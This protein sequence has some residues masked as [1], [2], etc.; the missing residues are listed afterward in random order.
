MCYLCSRTLFIGGEESEIEY[1]DGKVSIKCEAYPNG[2]PEEVFYSGHIYPKP[3]DN[4][5]HYEPLNPNWDIFSYFER[6]QEEEDSFYQYLI[7]RKGAK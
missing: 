1:K 2:V 7:K 5:L 6:T 3:G 4:G